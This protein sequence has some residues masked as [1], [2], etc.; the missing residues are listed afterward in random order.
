[1]SSLKRFTST[2]HTARDDSEYEL[3]MP[4]ALVEYGYA[5]TKLIAIRV[6]IYS[7]APDKSM[8]KHHQRPPLGVAHVVLETDRME[9][10]ARFMQ[11]IGMRP[12]FQ[13][14]G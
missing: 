4:V 5:A 13:G 11:T 9:E 7:K 2:G 10:S 8:S 1:M 3:D 6:P 12:I 14:H